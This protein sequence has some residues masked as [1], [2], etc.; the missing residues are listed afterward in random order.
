MRRKRPVSTPLAAAPEDGDGTGGGDGQEVNDNSDDNAGP[1]VA[2]KAKPPEGKVVFVTHGIRKIK[3]RVRNF[4]CIV[5]D[6]M[7]HKQKHLNDHIRQDHPQYRL[8]CCHC[9][10]VFCTANAAYKHE[11]GHAGKKFACKVCNKAF[12]FKGALK[13]H[14]KVHTGA[15][16]YPCTNCNLKF[17]SN[18]AMVW[19]AIRH[20]GKTYFHQKCPKKTSSPYDMRQHVQ[21]A[22]ERGFPCPCGAKEKWPRDVQKHKQKCAECKKL[23][24][25][26]TWNILNLRLN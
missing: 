26:A 22:H 5:C 11:V 15:G 18:R 4:G 17:A 3:K 2:K 12:Q 19:H 9:T 23:W 24:K 20:Q 16:M 25:K 13:D 21:G 1:S 7:F 6:E 8:K 14:L 10:R